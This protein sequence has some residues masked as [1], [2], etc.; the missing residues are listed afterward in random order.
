T[1]CPPCRREI[2]SVVRAYEQFHDQGFEVI[3]VSLDSD[4]EA[5]RTFARENAM[6]WRQHCDGQRFDG[7]LVRRFGVQGIPTTFLLNREGR[8]HE[9]GL[10]GEALVEAVGRLVRTIDPYDL[11]IRPAYL[12]IEVED[13]DGGARVKGVNADGSV[14]G[15][16]LPGDVIRSFAGV[17][18]DGTQ[19][20]IQ[21]VR[22]TAAGNTVSVVIVRE[23]TE[24]TFEVML[25]PRP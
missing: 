22:R 20:L 14:A 24:R 3:G 23:G 11:N 25:K 12:G 4:V 21:N 7:S 8:I 13:A 19:T 6:P 2:P 18:I 5:M 1:W 15:I 9:V 10:R 16:L 17:A